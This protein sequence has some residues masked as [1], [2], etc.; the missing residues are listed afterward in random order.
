MPL[1]TK[2]LLG[3]LLGVLLGIALG[4]RSALLP[5]TRAEVSGTLYQ[6][7]DGAPLAVDAA[8]QSALGA[9][10]APPFARQGELLAQKEG[11]RQVAWRVRTRQLIQ[12][13]AAGVDTTGLSPGARLEGW[14]RA[15]ETRTYSGFGQTLVDST[16]WIGDLF[17]QLIKMVV[18]PLVF[19]SL[20]VGVASLGDLRA[21]GR[22][23]GRTLLLFVGTTTVALSIGVTLANL[24]SPGTLI[25]DDDRATLLASYSADASG[26]VSS[27]AEAPGFAEQLLSIVPSNPV[28]ALAQGE[29]LQIIFFALMLGV[30]L[31]MMDSERAAPVIDVFDRLNDAMIM[32]VHLAMELAPYGVAALLFEVAGT[33]GASV[34]VALIGYT[35]VVVAGLLLHGAITYGGIVAGLARQSPVAFLRALRQPMLMAFSTSS[36]S[37]T[38][39]VTMQACEEEMGVSNRVASFVLPLGATVNMDGTA[40]YQGVAAVFIAQ[41]Y[42]MDLSLVQQ[43]TIVASATAASV[44]A[45]GVPGAGM[46]TL[47]MVLTAIGVPVEGIA[48]VIGVDRLLDMVRTTVNVVGDSAATVY[49]ATLEGEELSIQ[50]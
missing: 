29:M 9:G 31:T 6:A 3:M 38:L 40:L 34:L 46:I 1:H 39:P 26:K 16:S 32:L 28:A 41:V 21:L 30:A 48:L 45:A 47:A 15:P 17:L 37:A 4:P 12:L 2:I 44:G 5:Q 13:Q 20:V 24:A 19:F 11:W 7:P 42:G 43:L 10:E 50:G 22:L 25:A 18:V 49:M 33:T 23:G 27:A 35:L 8:I 36:S 14:A